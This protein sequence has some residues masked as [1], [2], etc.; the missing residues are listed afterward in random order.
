M[1]LVVTL[2]GSALIE[3]RGSCRA[4]A[5]TP[6]KFHC[7]GQ[8]YD[9]SVLLPEAPSGYLR[10]IATDGKSYYFGPC[11][12]VS[13]VT[14]EGATGGGMPVAVQAWSGMPPTIPSGSCAVLGATSPRNCSV[15]PSAGGGRPGMLCQYAGGS[16]GRTVDIRY[17]CDATVPVTH[18]A[19]EQLPGQVR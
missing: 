15:S 12:S 2:A 1:W 3:E 4:M 8:N 6:C 5:D 18:L 17:V 9:F 14:C 16:Q 19:A 11:G 10:A 13:G 7:P